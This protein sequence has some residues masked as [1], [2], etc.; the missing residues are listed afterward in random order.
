M[1]IFVTSCLRLCHSWHDKHDKCDK[2]VHNTRSFSSSKRWKKWAIFDGTNCAKPRKQR[3]LKVSRI[4]KGE[5]GEKNADSQ[6]VSDRRGRPGHRRVRVDDRFSCLGYLGC[7]PGK[8][9]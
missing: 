1:K 8:R 3:F 5:R 9:R 7:S 4:L 2:S 6:K